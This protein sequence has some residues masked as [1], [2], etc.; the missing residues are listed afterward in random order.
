MKFFQIFCV[1]CFVLL[2]ST[3]TEAKTITLRCS[4]GYTIDVTIELHIVLTQEERELGLPSSWTESLSCPP[5]QT[6]DLPDE[7]QPYDGLHAEWTMTGPGGGP[8]TTG[9]LP[10]APLAGE[11]AP[12]RYAY[13]GVRPGAPTSYIC[14][15]ISC[16]PDPVA[17][18]FIQ[19]GEFVIGSYDE[20]VTF[21]LTTVVLDAT[22]M[23][24]ISNASATIHRDA[25]S[26]QVAQGFT[27][28]SGRSQSALPA[29]DT[30]YIQVDS[31]GYH[32]QRSDAFQIFRDHEWRMLL[33]PATSAIAIS[34]G[35]TTSGSFLDN[36]Y[37]WVILFLL[38]L[39]VIL[40]A[41]SR[42]TNP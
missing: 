14:N 21:D 7:A 33:S 6:I 15:S 30:Y 2:G 24:P 28:A 17:P 32:P 4:P 37:A 26:S 19:T 29:G 35:R 27:A 31:S 25:D 8:P 9:S 42:R 40:I 1:L 18:T 20:A 22:T 5:D 16:D 38:V 41:R 3:S 12:G 13:W 34:T 11:P 23:L 36:W 39:I 10:P